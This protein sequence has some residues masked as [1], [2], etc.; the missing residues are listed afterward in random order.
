MA[1]AG[2]MYAHFKA[3]LSRYVAHR[4]SILHWIMNPTGGFGEIG[5]G[6]LRAVRPWDEWIAGWGFDMGEG[7]PDL[8]EENAL[9][10]FEHWSA[11]R[12]LTSRSARSH[13][14]T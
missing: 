12:N 2:T 7:D 13:P 9:Q 14:G 6:L 3:D 8:G 11:I 10:K 4:P 5:R 1:R